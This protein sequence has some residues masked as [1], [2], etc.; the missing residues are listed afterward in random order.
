MSPDLKDYANEVINIR[1]EFFFKE[2]GIS[3][4]FKRHFNRVQKEET[5]QMIL[6]SST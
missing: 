6:R 5:F 3:S 4:K 1:D 2:E